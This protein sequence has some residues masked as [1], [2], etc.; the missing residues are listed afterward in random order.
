MGKLRY[1]LGLFITCLSLQWAFVAH[2]QSYPTSEQFLP[3]ATIDQERLFADSLF[4]KAFNE[5]LRKDANALDEENTRIAKEL[6]DEETAL[7]EKRKELSNEEFRK[8]AATFN[9]KVETIRRDQSQKQKNL[10]SAQIKGQLAF[11]VKA[12]P[13]IVNLMNELGILFIL[14]D[15]AIFMAGNSGDITN[16]AIERIDQILGA[17]I[18]SEQ[19]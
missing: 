8:L 12:K 19:E 7:T 3:V 14:N 9:D 17:N 4:G 6:T 5:K 11:F 1:S 13:I 10:N 2:A 15:K 18:L 16:S